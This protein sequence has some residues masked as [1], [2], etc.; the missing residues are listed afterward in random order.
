MNIF[1]LNFWSHFMTKMNTRKSIL[2]ISMGL[3]IFSIHQFC[4]YWY[5]IDI[6]L[7]LVFFHHEFI[8]VGII[9]S[10]IASFILIF[11]VITF[12]FFWLIF[13]YNIIYVA[14]FQSD[15]GGL[16]YPTVLNQLFIEIYIMKLCVTRLFFLV[17][18][19]NRIYVCIEQT[20]I[21]IVITAFTVVFQIVLN[22]EFESFLQNLPFEFRNL[23]SQKQTITINS[24][25]KFKRFCG[26]YGKLNPK[27]TQTD[28]F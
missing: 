10:V 12:G 4:V 9:Y 27:L 13:R 8:F 7:N 20:M 24:Q 23:N 6:L 25:K 16:L 21:M 3:Y 19:K 17:R 14:I 1:R 22:N 2:W 5:M 11:S 28:E 15:T 26:V 18:K